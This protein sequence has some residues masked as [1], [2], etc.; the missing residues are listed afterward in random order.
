MDYKDRSKT[1]AVWEKF[2]EEN[3]MPKMVFVPAHTLWKGH[4]YEVRP[5]GTTADGEA[6]MD[7][8]Q[9]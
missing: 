9:F 6:E 3:Y 5:G 2:C 1:E 8:R 7:Q 4:S